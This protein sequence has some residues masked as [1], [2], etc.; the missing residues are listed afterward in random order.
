MTSSPKDKPITIDFSFEGSGPEQHGFPSEERQYRI[1]F[2]DRT[3]KFTRF[4]WHDAAVQEHLAGL[5][6]SN[7]DRTVLKRLGKRLR[8][9]LEDT[10]WPQ[11]EDEIERRINAKQPVDIV[12]SSNSP[13]I[14]ALP[15]ELLEIKRIGRW[16]GDLPNC[17]IHYDWAQEP[18]H[19]PRLP[20]PERILFAWS[21]AGGQVPFQ[22]HEEALREAL[23]RAASPCNLEL[24]ILPR[25]SH[26][27]LK[28]ALRDPERPVTILHLLCHGTKTGTGAPAVAL[29]RDGEESG[30]ERLDATEFQQFFPLGAPPRLV[31][32]CV[33]QSGDAGAPHILGSIAQNL[34]R[35]DIPAVIA[36]RMPL[37]CNGSVLLTQRLYEDL[38]A[39]GKNLR[40]AFLNARSEL[41]VQQRGSDW[42]SLQLY[43]RRNHDEAFDPLCRRVRPDATSPQSEVVLICHEAFDKVSQ[44]PEFA[45]KIVRKIVHIDQT[46]LLKQRQ[47]DN[48]EEAVESLTDPEGKLQQALAEQEVEFGYYGLPFIA[49]GALA[50]FLSG[51]SR[52]VHVFEPAPN[53]KQYV[54]LKDSDFPKLTLEEQ[55]GAAKRGAVRLRLSISSKVD[56]VECRKVLPDKRVR[57]DLHFTLPTP[58]PELVRSEEQ[59]RAYA[60]FLRET[61]HKHVNQDTEITSVHVFAAVPV[62]ISFL[63]GQEFSATWFPDCYVYNFGRSESPRYKWCL[64]LRAASQ[65]NP[66]IKIFNK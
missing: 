26:K 21:D 32:L 7:P 9:F 30:I 37:S 29:N 15:W 63:L 6:N 35:Q 24:D 44:R 33:C 19:E 46:P 55:P 42:L 64:N 66:S 31:V 11:A 60:E 43:A 14:Y 4:D 1:Q 12:I 50:G 36:S 62:S 45:D 47:W 27:S 22:K 3:S 28:L 34:H 16:L 39:G 56:L 48:L 25:A 5:A 40:D 54:W 49:L 8:D 38:L 65:H 2:R 59:A 10:N 18:S 58:N 53:T 61:V 41:H 51:R 52:R 20:R 17:L 13:E 23:K 57:L